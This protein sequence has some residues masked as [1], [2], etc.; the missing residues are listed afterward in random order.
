MDTSTLASK[1][2]T[3]WK[4]RLVSLRCAVLFALPQR[5]LPCQIFTTACLCI[6]QSV[7][8]TG[9]ELGCMTLQEPDTP[10]SV[11]KAAPITPRGTAAGSSPQ[12]NNST[13]LPSAAQQNVNFIDSQLQAFGFASLPKSS[14]RRQLTSVPESEVSTLLP[15]WQSPFEIT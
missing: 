15:L 3:A 6:L 4:S 8:I 10:R 14:S 7:W 1:S 11:K 2:F 9:Y 13:R 5:S 12:P